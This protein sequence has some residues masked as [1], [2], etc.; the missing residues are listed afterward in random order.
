MKFC[1][2]TGH[3]TIAEEEMENVENAIHVEVMQA[4]ESGYQHFISGFAEGGDLIFAQHVVNAIENDSTIHLYAALPNRA[5][6]RALL[7]NP[8]TR[9]MLALCDEIYIA[10]EG[11]HSGM[12]AQRNTYMVERS[13]RVIALYDGRKTGGTAF[14]VQLAKK[15][16][17]DLY[18]I[19]YP[20]R[21][22]ENENL[23][24]SC[25]IHHQPQKQPQ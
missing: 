25:S 14:T 18:V 12:Y 21:M 17:R 23:M 15:L 9:D 24:P 22:V 7:K 16:N 6:E 11:S 20:F 4:I 1:C 10:T 2:F 19:P 3:R 5:R 13:Q 8:E